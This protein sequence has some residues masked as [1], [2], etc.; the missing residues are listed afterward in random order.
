MQKSSLKDQ[1]GSACAQVC[2]NDVAEVGLQGSAPVSPKPLLCLAVQTS[3]G[4]LF[5]IVLGHVVQLPKQLLQAG[6]ARWGFIPGISSSAGMRPACSVHFHRR[7]PPNKL[8]NSAHNTDAAAISSGRVHIDSQRLTC[9]TC[10]V[11]TYPLKA[12]FLGQIISIA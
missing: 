2:S 10:S 11:A 8:T 9:L 1:G 12:G 5:Q 4:A 3:S 7:R 6:E